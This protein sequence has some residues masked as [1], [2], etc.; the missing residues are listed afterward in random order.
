MNIKIS[1]K[2]T[3][4]IFV[5]MMN[6]CLDLDMGDC[7]KYE[8]G[9]FRFD[10]RMIELIN[11]Y[12]NKWEKGKRKHTECIIGMHEFMLIDSAYIHEEVHNGN[13]DYKGVK[14]DSFNCLKESPD[15]D[16]LLS[17]DAIGNLVCSHKDFYVQAEVLEGKN[18]YAS[19]IYRSSVVSYWKINHLLKRKKP[20]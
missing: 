15:F 1:G 12:L 16:P 14:L 18:R 10:N 17:K 7:K 11:E 2:S 6:Y 4:H 5:A 3:D 20:L 19:I 13:T 9:Y 8:F